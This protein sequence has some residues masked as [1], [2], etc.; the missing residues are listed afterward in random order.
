MSIIVKESEKKFV[1]APEGTTQAVCFGVWDI[2]FQHEKNMNKKSESDPETVLKHKMYI[3]FEI[4]ETIQEGEYKGKRYC[5]FK[6]YTVSLH[7]KSS[8]RPALESWRGR[9]FTEEEL[10]GFDIERLIGANC[11]LNIV[12]NGDYANISGI[13]A[14]PKNTIKMIPEN[15]PDMPEWISK[16]KEKSVSLPSQEVDS[17]ASDEEIPL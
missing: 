14:C 11:L 16:I 15:K 10:K 13:M 17:S 1:K 12:H 2:G 6:K 8:L 3:G 4:S 9:N 7:K 5:L